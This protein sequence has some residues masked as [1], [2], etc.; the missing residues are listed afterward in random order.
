[1]FGKILLIISNLLFF[2]FSQAEFCNWGFVGPKIISCKGEK[3]YFGTAACDSGIYRNL[4]CHEKFNQSGKEC[5]DDVLPE[6]I[7]CYNQMTGERTDPISK[8]EEEG[9]C[10]WGFAGPKIVTCSGQ[11]FCFGS[12]VCQ[13]QTYRNIFC[14]EDN[15]G[16]GKKCAEDSDEITK[17]C[18]EQFIQT[19]PVSSE[20][21]KS[22]K[23]G[24]GGVR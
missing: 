4:F 1:M 14:K 2:N 12:T 9:F 10:N 23:N 22:P 3:Y 16:S 8:N 21:I 18:Y 17:N 5:S 15:C 19:I 24:V 6:T 11:R 20:D 7:R 13:N